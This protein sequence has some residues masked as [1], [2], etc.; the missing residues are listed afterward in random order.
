[1]AS[2]DQ[3]VRRTA[4]QSYHDQYL[5]YKNTFASNLATSIK[6]NVLKMRVRRYPT[7]VEMALFKDNIPVEVFHNLL[8]TFRRNSPVWERY[9]SVRRRALGVETLHSY[10]V[11]APLTADSPEVSY[12]QGVEWVAQ[13]LTPLGDDY[14]DLIRRGCLEERWVDVPEQGQNIRGIFGRYAGDLPVHCHEL[15]QGR[16]ELGYPGS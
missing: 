10:D 5:A 4:W 1:M 8:E 9:W 12:E 15:Q 3:E 2:P 6:Q 11:W 13:A 14:A 7:T 16:S